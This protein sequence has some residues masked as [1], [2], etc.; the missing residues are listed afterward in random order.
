MAPPRGTDLLRGVNMT[1]TLRGGLALLVLFGVAAGAAPPAAADVIFLQDGRTIRAETVEV[2]G[3]RVRV[4]RGTETIDLPKS[5]VLSVHTPRPAP[6]STPPPA[7]VYP[8]FVQQMT[9][10]V[11]NELGSGMATGRVGR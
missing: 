7:A 1:A 8:D 11:R 4:R 3:D 6:P 5:E 2:L 10:R 9:D